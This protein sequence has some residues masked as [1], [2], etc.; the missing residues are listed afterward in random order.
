M[1][2][3]F[4]TGYDFLQP[5]LDRRIF[6]EAKSCFNQGHDVEI[7]C[8]ARRQE[9]QEP[10]GKYEE[11]SFYRLYQDLGP[12]SNSFLF[13]IPKYFQLTKQMLA[14]LSEFRPDV[15]V[16]VDLEMLPVAILGKLYYNYKLIYD[17]HEDWPAME[18]QTSQF[19][20]Y[21]TKIMEKLLLPFVDSVITVCETLQKRFDKAG[22]DSHLLMTA[23]SKSEVSSLSFRLRSE[24]R[25]EL[26]FTEEDIVVGFIGNLKNKN[27]EL[28]LAT[29]SHIQ[30]INSQSNLRLLI[31]GSPKD[32]LSNLSAKAH[33]MNLSSRVIF[34]SVVPY[35]EVHNYIQALDLG[36]TQYNDVPWAQLA[37]PQKIIDYFAFGVPVLTRNFYERAKLVR[38]SKA[39]LVFQGIEPEIVSKTIIAFESSNLLPRLRKVAKRFFLDELSWENQELK[40][41]SIIDNLGK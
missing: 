23:R 36:I 6:V 25:K 29:F 9:K 8:W 35:N 21:S 30:E 22:K 10:T 19:L 3:A 24:V 17:C 27:L 2:V 39:G 37:L 31:L 18:S 41:I 4:L 34:H 7:I 28:L 5:K 12:E 40:L 32:T 13:K 11:I 20:G 26:G 33:K 1:R 16:A 14:R 38:K 15:V